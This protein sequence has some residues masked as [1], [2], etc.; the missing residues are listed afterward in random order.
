MKMF[1]GELIEDPAIN[2]DE[3]NKMVVTLMFRDTCFTLGGKV[4]IDVYEHYVRGN[5]L[6]VYVNKIGVV[7]QVIQY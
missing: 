3:N 7:R 1:A 4:A 6:Q 2:I 5:C